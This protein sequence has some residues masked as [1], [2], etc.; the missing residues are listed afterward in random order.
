MP[1]RSHVVLL[2]LL[3]CCHVIIIGS[4]INI[5]II[6]MIVIYCVLGRAAEHAHLIGELVLG[7]GAGKHRAEEHADDARHAAGALRQV[8]DEEAGEEDEEHAVAGRMRQAAHP[9]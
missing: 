4:V 2:F 1:L 9:S 5:I 6:I 7:E 8:V 3:D